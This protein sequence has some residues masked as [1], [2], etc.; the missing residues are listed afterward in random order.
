MPAYRPGFIS[1][2]Q[3]RNSIGTWIVVTTVLILLLVASS[4]IGSLGWTSGG[5]VGVPTSG[6]V[7]MAFGVRR[8]RDETVL[9]KP[10]AAYDAKF[11]NFVI[12]PGFFTRLI[13]ETV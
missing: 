8:S 2:S 1:S 10:T 6:Y 3:R 5:D 11:V 9:A 13:Y 7:A 12:D 4:V